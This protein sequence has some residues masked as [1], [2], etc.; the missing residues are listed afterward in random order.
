MKAFLLPWRDRAL[1]LLAGLAAALAHPPFGFLPGLLGYGLI[2]WLTERADEARPLRS[3]FLHGWL[4]GAPYFAVSTWWVAEAFYVDAANQ[5]WMAPFAV[6][7]MSTG[8]AL[9]WGGAAVLYRLLATR[10]VLRVLVFAGALTAFEWLR[11]H[12]LTGFPWNLPGET[13]K[14]GSYPSQFAAVVG[15]YGLTWITV[16]AAAAP[17][18]LMKRRGPREWTAVAAAALGV[19]VLYAWGMT[20]PAETAARDGPAIR[21]VQADIKQTNKYDQA[22]FTDIVRRY[23]TLTAQAPAAGKPRPGIVIWPEGAIPAAADDYLAPGTWTRAAIEQ[24]LQPGQILLLG[25]YRV[26]PDPKKDRYYNTFIAVR[27]SETG[28]D[29]LGHYDKFRLVPFGEYM[30]ADGLMAAI[31]FKTLVHVGDGF[32]PGP[33]PQPLAVPGLGPIQP[34]ICYESLFPGFTRQGAARSG[35]RPL[36]IVN[37]SNDAWYGVTSGPLQN[38][39]ISAYRAI[40]EGLPML[41]ATPTGVSA[42]IDPHGR[43]MFGERLDLGKNGVIDARLPPPGQPTIYSRLGDAPLWLFLILSLSISAPRFVA[44]ALKRRDNPVLGDP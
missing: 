38:L 28:L 2:L 3:A 21:I 31:G 30:P 4:A 22:Y 23:V 25:A 33:E 19:V 13:W 16:A 34:L 42:V 27:R 37:V 43:I 39:N 5:G 24:S 8:L 15:A 1:A 40:E 26:E 6:L 17:A 14:A 11:G 29:Y 18:L 44:L 9:F 36:A 10:G 7:F 20:R 35:R 12:I 41:R 32:S